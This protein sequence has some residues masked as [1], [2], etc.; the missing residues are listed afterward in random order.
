MYGGV[1]EGTG[2]VESMERG[3]FYRTNVQLDY[4]EFPLCLGK[5]L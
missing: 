2:D 3:K 4:A 5:Q 1:T